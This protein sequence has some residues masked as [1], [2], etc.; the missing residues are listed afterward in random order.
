MQEAQERYT[1]YY[2]AKRQDSS[3]AFKVGDLVWLNRKNIDTTRPSLK[4]DHKLLGP[5][6]IKAKVNDLAFTLDLPAT[7][8][9]HPTFGVSLLE[10]YKPGHHNQPQDPPARIDID[11]HD[12]ERFFP[13]RILDAKFDNGDYFYLVK[14]EGSSDEYNTWETNPPSSTSAHLQSVQATTSGT[15]ISIF[16]T[17]TSIAGR[18]S[19][20]R[21]EVV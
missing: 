18:S 8:E 3:N 9:C 1:K 16:K 11:S 4:L 2:D 10:K 17:T 19:R 15:S 5:F 21:R 12:Y 20:L 6:R 13:E 14:W 7:M